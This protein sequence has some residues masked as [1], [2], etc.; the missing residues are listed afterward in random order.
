MQSERVASPGMIGQGATR[1]DESATV[2]TALMA[3]EQNAEPS[4]REEAA[5]T[6]V[7]TPLHSYVAIRCRRQ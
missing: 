4:R 6:G 1:V 7:F 5:V 3:I 2:E